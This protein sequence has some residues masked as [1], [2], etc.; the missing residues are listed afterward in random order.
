MACQRPAHPPP[1][2]PH[3]ALTPLVKIKLGDLVESLP[4]TGVQPAGKATFGDGG[5]PGTCGHF[6]AIPARCVGATTKWREWPPH[7]RG[8]A[9]LLWTA[10]RGLTSRK[11]PLKG[12]LLQGSQDLW[13]SLKWIFLNK[14][15][16]IGKWF[17]NLFPDSAMFKVMYIEMNFKNWQ[18]LRKVVR[19]FFRWCMRNLKDGLIP[20]I[21][22]PP[23]S[24]MSSACLSHW[25]T[26]R[27]EESGIIFWTT[28]V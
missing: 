20:S 16:R 4:S 26:Q 10:S 23:Q 12:T 3:Q 27:G 6:P 18:H 22:C 9:Y 13:I 2:T 11:C 5:S 24:N 1:P 25:Q 7:Q 14:S 28:C 17:L 21:I 15:M 8:A 19:I